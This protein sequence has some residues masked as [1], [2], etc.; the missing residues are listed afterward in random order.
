[1]KR[2]AVLG[3]GISGLSAANF[4]IREDIE[5]TV[6]E[7]SNQVGG[8][9]N[10]VTKDG[11]HLETG[12]NSVMLNNPEFLDLL[13]DLKLT[14]SII[15]PEEIA[16]KNRFI[17]M[18]KKPVALPSGPGNLLGNKI[19]GWSGIATILK[20]PFRKQNT[21]TED[22]SLASFCKRRF[23]H[24]LLDNVIAPFVT[25][26]YA[27]DPE[28]MSAKYSMKALWEAEKNHGS[29]IKGMMKSMKEKK[30]DPRQQE[31]PKQKMI[32]FKDG[33]R[34]IPELIQSKL[35]D[36]L[37]LNSTVTAVEKLENGYQITYSKKSESVQLE[38]DYIISALPAFTEAN[39]WKMQYPT[40]SDELNKVYYAPTVA[41]HLGY[42]KSQVKNQTPGFGI[43]TRVLE[44]KSYLGILF[45]NRF[46][47]HNAPKDK[48][49]FAIIIGGAR[50]PELTQLPKEELIQQIKKEL[51]EA[52]DITGEPELVNYI[53][54]EKGIPQYNLGHENLIKEEAL[55]MKDNPNY[56]I[57]GNYIHGVSVADSIKKGVLAAK[58]IT[59]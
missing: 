31:L 14:D 30:A 10:T 13:K 5:L 56:R 34:T 27:G 57:I 37:K 23:S 16:A 7:K 33:L 9:M 20:E 43:L 46:F 22:E 38:V 39:F 41:I 45:I 47:P 50:S 48:D 54:W 49:L 21:N 40:F 3:A 29:I 2:V 55:F 8:L 4:L 25:G 35:G 42:D 19:I 18:G 15:F 11:Y 58:A 26:V 36:R 59:A 44:K 12:P 28:K 1:M 52:M 32:S 17:L 6:I 51:A 53:N 24:S